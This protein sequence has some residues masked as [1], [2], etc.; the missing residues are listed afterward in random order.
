[1]DYFWLININLIFLVV[2]SFSTAKG[3][4]FEAVFNFINPC[5]RWIKII[6]D[7]G[8]HYHNSELMSIISHWY[9]WYGVEVRGWI[10]LKPGEAKITVD[11]HHT[12]V[13]QLLIDFLFVIQYIQLFL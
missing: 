8:G 6:S 12:M 3:P 11:S 10:F 5:S 4:Y 13:C 7:N 9:D 2:S 1:M